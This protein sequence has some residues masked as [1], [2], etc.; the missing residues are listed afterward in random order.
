[1][2]DQSARGERQT[3]SYETDSVRYELVIDD[4]ACNR[5]GLAEVFARHYGRL[6]LPQVRTA[7]DVG[8]G[9]G[10][11]SI[12]LADQHDLRVTAVEINAVAHRCCRENLE[13]YRVA[14]SVTTW[15]INFADAL[16]KL[17][18]DAYDL[19]VANPP[20][21]D[22]C[23]PNSNSG[24]LNAQLQRGM[25][26]E[27]FMYLTNA[28]RDERGLDLVD[29][30]FRFADRRLSSRGRI[31]LV[32]CDI[33][34]ESQE[35]MARKLGLYG[36]LQ[37]E[38]FECSILPGRIGVEDRTRASIPCHLFHLRRA[39]GGHRPESAGSLA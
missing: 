23:M 5:F 35:Y 3:A 25:N 14:D 39:P 16:S 32:C 22:G 36:Y 6:A 38:R 20:M 8:C 2:R 10:P 4:F 19:I 26:G 12:F 34:V 11:I 17:P 13:R 37:V 31:L 7:L 33:E 1:M 28:W 18:I 15:N 29:H 9:V 30:I 27:L 24:P 21:G